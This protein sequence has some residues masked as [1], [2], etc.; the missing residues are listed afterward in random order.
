MLWADAIQV[1][2]RGHYMRNIAQKFRR[3]T[4]GLGQ[5][6]CAFGTLPSLISNGIQHILQRIGML[7]TGQL[8]S[9]ALSVHVC[10]AIGQA[11]NHATTL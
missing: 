10:V 5:N 6:P 7:Q 9:Q 8:M 2:P 1:E 4:D 11:R 3:L